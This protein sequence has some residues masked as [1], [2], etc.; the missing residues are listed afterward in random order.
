[1]K[2]ELPVVDA[3]YAVLLDGLRELR[4]ELGPELVRSLDAVR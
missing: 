3:A 2:G 4:V 1:V